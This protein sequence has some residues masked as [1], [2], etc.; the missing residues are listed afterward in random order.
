MRPNPLRTLVLIRDTDCKVCALLEKGLLEGVFRDLKCGEKTST[1]IIHLSRTVKSR[2]SQ[3]LGLSG[4]ATYKL[5][6]GLL[7]ID[8]PS[9][10][11]CKVFSSSPCVPRQAVYVPGVG[12]IFSLLTPSPKVA[13]RVVERLVAAGKT[14]EVVEEANMELPRGLTRKQ[15]IVLMTAIKKGYLNTPRECTLS[16]L[17]EALGLSKSTVY[18]CLK[19]ALK[20]LALEALLGYEP[21]NFRRRLSLIYR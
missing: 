2:G 17:A 20:K 12:V 3:K 8:A 21:T 16:E 7:L 13:R 9:C 18:R 15:F 1:H 5:A 14:V 19:T 6:G 10:T 4:A 11:A